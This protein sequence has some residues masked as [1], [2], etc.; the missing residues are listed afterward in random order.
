MMTDADELAAYAR[1]HFGS[2]IGS[3]TD[4]GQIGRLLVARHTPG[5]R[6]WTGMRILRSLGVLVE[7][8]DAGRPS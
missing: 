1:L 2:A 6:L 8:D 4:P 5:P 7:Q 3:A